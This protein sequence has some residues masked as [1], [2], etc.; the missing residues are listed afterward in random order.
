VAVYLLMAILSAA[1]LYAAGK[2]KGYKAKCLAFLALLSPICVA[3]FRKIG[4]GTDT[5]VY[6]DALYKAAKN[7]TGFFDYLGKNVYSSFQ[8]KPVTSWEI[9]YNVILYLSTKLTGSVQGILFVTHLLIVF[10]VLPFVQKMRAPKNY[11]NCNPLPHCI[12]RASV[13]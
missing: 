1:L 13:K 12:Q 5:E 2:Q 8:Y 7:S 10:F 3:G 4:I 9:G 6:V 11:C